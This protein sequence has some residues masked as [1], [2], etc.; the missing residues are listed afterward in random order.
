MNKYTEATKQRAKQPPA[1]YVE[2]CMTADMVDGQPLP[3]LIEDGV[4]WHVVRRSNRRT[5]W[6]RISLLYASSFPRSQASS[7]QPKTGRT[8]ET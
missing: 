6:R 2:H 7:Y 8:S 3:P 4:V 1:L 5:T